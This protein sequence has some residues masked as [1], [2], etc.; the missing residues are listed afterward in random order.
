MLSTPLHM[1]IYFSRSFTTRPGADI[2]LGLVPEGAKCG[3]NRVS[4]SHL[5]AIAL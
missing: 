3:A 5:I 4:I 2:M 1:Y